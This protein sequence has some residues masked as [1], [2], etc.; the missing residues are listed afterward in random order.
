[1]QARSILPALVLFAGSLA[2]QDND[3]PARAGRVSSVAG[4]VAF[5]AAGTPD[6]STAPLNYTVTTGDHLITH[7]QSRA[8]IEVGPFAVRLADSTDLSVVNL[9]DTF[10]QLG[11]NR[12]TLRVSVYRLG[13]R[14]SMEV[15]TPNGAMIIRSAG[16]YRVDVLE[17]VS[18]IVSVEDGVAELSG[19]SLDYT[20]KRGQS[21]E[22]TGTTAISANMIQHPA[23]SDFD[24]W[25]V[26]RDNR[27][28]QS[29]CSR[30]MS[31]DIPG[32]AD[33]DANGRWE[34]QATYGYVW[35]PTVVSVGWV[36]YRSGRW[37]WTGPWGWSWV[38]SSPWGFAPF[39]YGRWVAVGGVWL[40]APGP[41]IVRPYY[42]PALVVFVGGPRYHQA[43]FP[44]GWREPYYP[45][46]R[47]SDR[48]LRQ[49]NIANVRSI[50]NVDEFVDPRRADRIAY[51]N[52][53][54][55]TV[56][57]N[58]VFGRR[59][60]D[61]EAITAVRQ[62]EIARAPVVRDRWEATRLVP[63][64]ADPV[65]VADPVRVSNPVRVADP[66]DVAPSQ[67][68]GRSSLIFRNSPPL[69]RPR[70]ESGPSDA[71]PAGVL[72]PRRELQAAP[73]TPTPT[74]R[75]R[76]LV[77]RSEPSQLP[78]APEPSDDRP[79]GV[80]ERS[81]GSNRFPQRTATPRESQPRESQPRE[82][83]PRAQSEPRART[84]TAQR[85]PSRRPPN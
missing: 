53:Q 31:R 25:S 59:Q 43:W 1:M 65:G 84:G 61:R 21:V 50:S 10:T 42:A 33:L 55:T 80:I 41:I 28:Q 29:T 58:E 2:A 54:A 23:N 68:R 8:E 67:P 79:R 19:P 76:P 46:Y 56:V 7:R 20:V 5:Q 18:T 71:S 24:Q 6:W 45:R 26:D 70:A 51:S 15:D 16:R 48:Y 52:R 49:V 64:P 81:S 40:W 30:Y 17:G 85:L 37:V 57:S 82:A 72:R 39:H 69:E 74:E 66:V 14:D 27:Q 47:H 38:E 9:T 44:L 73:D 77:R 35:R 60:L 75:S 78:S 34:Y 13:T 62:D 22:L 63:R 3:P 83:S 32:C 11:L 36:P 4:T 12:G